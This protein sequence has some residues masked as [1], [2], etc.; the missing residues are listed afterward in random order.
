MIKE[1]AEFQPDAFETLVGDQ[2][3]DDCLS[4]SWFNLSRSSGILT[5][6]KEEKKSFV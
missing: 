2:Q 6:V 3:W 5:N 1:M 4:N